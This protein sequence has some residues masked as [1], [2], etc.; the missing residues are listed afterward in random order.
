MKR[1]QGTAF[2]QERFD[3]RSLSPALRNRLVNTT[4]NCF[5]FYFT[6]QIDWGIEAVSSTNDDTG[7]IDW[8][9]GNEKTSEGIDWGDSGDAAIDW[10]TDGGQTSSEEAVI[11]WGENDVTDG[12]VTLDSSGITLEDSGQGKERR[13][14]MTNFFQELCHE[15]YQF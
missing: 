7:N 14:I 4:L 3:L 11:D 5:I 15:M 2:E 9:E 6:S 10:G 1:T 8:G 13:C 12:G